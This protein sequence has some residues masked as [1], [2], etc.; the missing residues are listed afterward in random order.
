VKNAKVFPEKSA[1]NR[2]IEQPPTIVL[3]HGFLIGIKHKSKSL[4]RQWII[5]PPCQM[6]PSPVLVLA[7]IQ[8]PQSHQRSGRDFWY[9]YIFADKIREF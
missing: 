4:P 8:M 5:P 6:I 7:Q 2:D 1:L 9:V 3:D